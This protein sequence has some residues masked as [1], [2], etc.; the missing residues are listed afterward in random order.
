[1]QKNLIEMENKYNELK[2]NYD[3]ISDEKKSFVGQMNVLRS[4]KNNYA[5]EYN[6]NKEVLNNIKNDYDLLVKQRDE[7]KKEKIMLKNELEIIKKNNDKMNAI[8]VSN[9]IKAQSNQKLKDTINNLTNEK[10]NLE[11]KN[12]ILQKKIEDLDKEKIRSRSQ[13]KKHVLG[14]PKMFKNLKKATGNKFMIT[15]SD[16]KKDGSKT[17]NIKSKNKSINKKKKF[18]KLS[19]TKNT[20]N[21][22]ILGKF[23]KNIKTNKNNSKDKSKDKSKE[24][25]KKIIKKE[26]GKSGAINPVPTPSPEKNSFKEIRKIESFS[27]IGTKKSG[28]NINE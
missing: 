28:E 1:M 17:T 11:K 6:K 16:V 12:D 2:K 20:V 10:N 18:D 23:K 22:L 14:K 21:V 24:K 3:M 27:F 8:K 19:I 13:P 7:Y 26:E 15:K 4:Q 9:N 5:K 25:D